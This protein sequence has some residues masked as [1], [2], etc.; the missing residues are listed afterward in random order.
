MKTYTFRDFKT[1]LINN[2]YVEVR[3][4]GDHHIFAKVGVAH[5][6]SINEKPNRCVCQR[7]I[8]HNKLVVG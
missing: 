7:L 6:I 5:H 3:R 8:K 4:S 1:V 2:G